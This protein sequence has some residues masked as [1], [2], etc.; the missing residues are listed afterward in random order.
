[1]IKFRYKR[2]EA[3]ND[4][5]TTQQ[6]GGTAI[7][8][9]KIEGLKDRELLP[10]KDMMVAGSLVGVRH[11]TLPRARCSASSRQ[12]DPRSLS[13]PI[14]QTTLTLFRVSDVMFCFY[15]FIYD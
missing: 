9:E 3:T 5:S 8:K 10:P 6:K 11:N 4:G 7:Q 14:P 15:Y 13:P 1:M 12:H 2:K